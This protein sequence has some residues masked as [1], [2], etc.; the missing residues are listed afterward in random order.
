[1]CDVIVF[2]QK[3][4]ADLALPDPE[5]RERDDQ[6]DLDALECGDNSPS[7]SGSVPAWAAAGAA[8]AVAAAFSGGGGAYGGALPQARTTEQVATRGAVPPRV[9]LTAAQLRQELQQVTEGARADALARLAKRA[10]GK[11]PKHPRK[12]T[13]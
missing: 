8:E 6:R 10:E 4:P 9:V 11:G 5:E 12:G 13:T 2:V 1:V 3:R 7:P